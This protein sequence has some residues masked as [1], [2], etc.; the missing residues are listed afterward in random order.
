MDSIGKYL[1]EKRESQNLSI[2]KISEEIKLKE[3]ILNQIENDDFDAIGD[4]GFIK[5]MVITY[6]RALGGDEELVLRNIKAKFDKKTE[7][8]IKINTAK[9]RKRP[10]LLS[11]GLIYFVL[12]ILLVFVLSLSVIKF[13]K[14]GSMS[15]K[16]I[17]EQLAF[18]DNKEKPVAEEKIETDVDSLWTKHREIFNKT[19]Q[20]NDDNITVINTTKI[21]TS[22]KTNTQEITPQRPLNNNHNYLNDNTDYVNL[23]IFNNKKTPLNQEIDFSKF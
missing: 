17:R 21:D 22:N 20:I 18:S 5:I 23:L 1:K 15:F 2:S 4:I 3:Y 9:K 13:Y 8:P 16:A 12:L 6:C 10:I 11:M 7:P 19:N 14:Q